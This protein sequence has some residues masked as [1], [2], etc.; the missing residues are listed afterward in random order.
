MT[1]SG[2][3][4]ADSPDFDDRQASAQRSQPVSVTDEGFQDFHDLCRT[5]IARKAKH[6]NPRI[7][8]WWIVS[9]VGEI[10]VTRNQRLPLA[11]RLRRNDIVR[12][13]AQSDVSDIGYIMSV[14]TKH[15]GRRTR[16]ARVH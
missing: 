12:G 15:L 11:P 14:L 9:Y 4:E 1:K 13:V 2:R 16:Q 6:N 3:T 8:A 10:E 7:F 5:C